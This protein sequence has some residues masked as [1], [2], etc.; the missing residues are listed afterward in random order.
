M[1]NDKNKADAPEAPK[2]S[3]MELAV[4]RGVERWLDEN[5]RNTNFSQDTGAWNVLQKAIPALAPA[6]MREI[7]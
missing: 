3:P 5:L 7:G 2:P 4:A 6:I 1:A